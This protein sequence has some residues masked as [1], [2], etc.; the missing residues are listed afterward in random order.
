MRTLVWAWTSPAAAGIAAEPP[1]TK[2]AELTGGATPSASRRERGEG[3]LTSGT[4]SSVT[5]QREERTHSVRVG[6][7]GVGRPAGQFPGRPLR[8]IFFFF[9]LCSFLLHI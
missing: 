3:G 1:H 6:H 2:K 8:S 5:A 9:F 4:R 7:A